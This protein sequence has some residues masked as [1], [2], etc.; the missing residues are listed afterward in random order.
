MCWVCFFPNSF[1]IFLF[2]IGFE[3]LDCS[4]LH[5]CVE[6][7]SYFLDMLVGDSQPVWKLFWPFK[8]VFDLSLSFFSLETLA[9]CLLSYLKLPTDHR[10]CFHFKKYFFSVFYFI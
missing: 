9:M 1:N 10:L 4:F 7:L 6:G 2:I 8:Y 5:I 3:K